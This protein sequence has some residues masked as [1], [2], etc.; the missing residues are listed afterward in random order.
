[1]INVCPTRSGSYAHLVPLVLR[2]HSFPSGWR[3]EPVPMAHQ[4]WTCSPGPAV[5]GCAISD[6]RDVPAGHTK[7]HLSVLVGAAH[8]DGSRPHNVDVNVRERVAMIG[9]TNRRR[10]SPLL[11]CRTARPFPRSPPRLGGQRGDRVP[12]EM[13]RSG[14][15]LN[16]TCHRRCTPGRRASIGG[17]V[18]G[19]K[20]SIGASSVAG[21][22]GSPGPVHPAHRR[23]TSTNP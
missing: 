2:E 13:S 19:A 21:L 12:V 11:S 18:V 10:V 3:S 4:T 16:R 22:R 15:R 7:Y 5:S 14:G 9:A 20:S 17:F 1:M 8:W 6:G 23:C